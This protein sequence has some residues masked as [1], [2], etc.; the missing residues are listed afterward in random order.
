M[1]IEKLQRYLKNRHKFDRK[2]DASDTADDFNKYSKELNSAIL[3]D[4]ILRLA[5]YPL[6]IHPSVLPKYRGASP[7]ARVL[8]SGEKKTGITIL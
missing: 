7:V 8:M 1:E 2:K 4:N 5:K 6:N 3:K